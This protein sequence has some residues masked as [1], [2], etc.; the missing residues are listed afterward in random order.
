MKDI[1]RIAT[2]QSP[3]ALWQ[4][5]F[6]K[7]E[8]EKHFS[9]LSV[10]LVPITTKGDVILDTPLAKIGG[11]GLFVK[12]LELALLQNRADIAVHSM[13]DVPMSFPEG[14]GLAVICERED[15]RDAFISNK[16][17]SLDDLPQGAV[18]GT[19]SLRRQCQLMAKYPNLDVKSLRGNVGT[20]LS[21]LDN[22]EYDAIIL[23]SAGLIRLGLQERIRSYI[24]VEQSLPAVGQGAVG[25]ETRIDDERVLSYV[26][27]L[28]HN[29]TACCV[30]AERAMNNR[31]QGGCQVPIGGFATLSGDEI[32]LNALVGALD[33][34]QII[35]ASAKG[36]KDDAEQL[37]IAVADQLLAEGADKILAEVY[38][39]NPIK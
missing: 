21:K 38:S 10:E 3:L 33:G 15:P 26:A 39:H 7:N 5:N 11:K 24:S 12:E 22:G 13:K 17:P 29:L 14:L 27:K 6:V 25:I 32:T 18:V 20:R 36:H 9:Q 8:L 23:A 4:A 35:R 1:L 2:R 34:S 37:G 31:L 28:N 19:S 16:Y 30:M